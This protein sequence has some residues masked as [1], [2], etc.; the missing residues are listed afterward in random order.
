MRDIHYTFATSIV[1]CDLRTVY[2]VKLLSIFHNTFTDSIK[3]FVYFSVFSYSNTETRTWL[4]K[5]PVSIKHTYTHRHTRA[6]L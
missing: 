3:M 4:L 2:S 5:T 1:I 6:F